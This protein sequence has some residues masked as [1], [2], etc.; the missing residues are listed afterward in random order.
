M[1]IEPQGLGEVS[2]LAVRTAG[3]AATR[4]RV[5]AA[6]EPASDGPPA[7]PRGFPVAATSPVELWLSVPRCPAP[8]ISADRFDV[9]VRSWSGTHWVPVRLK[10]DLRL[11]CAP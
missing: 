8:P 9:R 3:D 11:R 5:L 6:G 1:P 2:V 7:P 10:P 4:T